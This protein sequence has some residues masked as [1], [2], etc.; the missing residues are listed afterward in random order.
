MHNNLS[1]LNATELL[2]LKESKW[3]ILC[4]AHFYL[5][6][7]EK[8]QSEVGMQDGIVTL[9][10][11]WSAFTETKYTC[12]PRP[13]NFTLRYGPNKDPLTQRQV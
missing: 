2:T 5:N 3:S 1:V 10:N 4:Y 9:E 7:K 12:S 11:S 6:K 13:S 8:K